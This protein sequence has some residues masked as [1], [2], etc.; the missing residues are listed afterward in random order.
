MWAPRTKID[1]RG[2][3]E[4][5]FGSCRDVTVRP[6]MN[7]LPVPVSTYASLPR[8]I[9]RSPRAVSSMLAHRRGF[10]GTGRQSAASCDM[11]DNGKAEP[12]AER[13]RPG[14]YKVY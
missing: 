8:I 12:V 6:E 7:R 3:T 11:S 14:A 4:W 13:A 5:R 1:H 9:K 10:E 2:T